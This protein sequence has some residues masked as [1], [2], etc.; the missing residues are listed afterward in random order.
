MLAKQR[1]REGDPVVLSR[2][3]FSSQPVDDAQSLL[4][5]ARLEEASLWL[6]GHNFEELAAVD[7]GK[8]SRSRGPIIFC[9]SITSCSRFQD[10][11]LRK[12]N[13]PMK[14]E[15]QATGMSLKN[16]QQNQITYQ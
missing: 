9:P 10:S 6:M 14:G 13:Q 12:P 11:V 5:R 16:N 1:K 2:Q 3:S 15:H 4:P 7:V 8:Q